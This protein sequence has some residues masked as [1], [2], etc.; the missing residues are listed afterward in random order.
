[1]PREAKKRVSK[2]VTVGV[3]V[4]RDNRLEIVVEENDSGQWSSDS[5]VLW[6]GRR[7]N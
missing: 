5:M 3:V 4:W 2:F 7:Q 1:M 6:L